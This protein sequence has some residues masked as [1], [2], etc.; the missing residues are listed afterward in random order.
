MNSFKPVLQLLMI[1]AITSSK[2]ISDTNVVHGDTILTDSIF[3]SS[4]KKKEVRR[5]KNKKIDGQQIEWY[6]SGKIKEKSIYKDDCPLD[7]MISFFEN[8]NKSHIAIFCK[9]K[10]NGIAISWDS[11]GDTVLFKPYHNGKPVGF[12]QEYYSKG[13]PSRFTHYD[14]LGRKQGLEEYWQENGAR[15]DSAFFRDNEYVEI[16]QYFNDGKPRLWMKYSAPDVLD[17]AIAYAP[18]GKNVSTVSKG[19]GDMM[20][21]SED[22]TQIFIVRYTNGKY[23]WAKPLKDA[24]PKTKEK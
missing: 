12:H 3:Y 7:T 1:A 11:L 6:E 15:G 2:I 16:R 24:L 18:D 23:E 19:S 17:T 9:C 5:Y 14:S 13:K 10:R 20:L 8:G 22:Q 21:F 4:G